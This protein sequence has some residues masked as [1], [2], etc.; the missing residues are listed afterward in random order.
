MKRAILRGPSQLEFEDIHLNADGLSDDQIYAETEFSA[1]SVGTESAAYLGQPPLRPG[2]P[3]PRFVGYCNAGK[4]TRLGRE[5]RGFKVGDRILT[6]QSHQSAFV[7]RSE[8]VLAWVPEFVSTKVASL[9]YLAHLGLAAL[10][11]ANF[12]PGENIAVLGLGLIGLATVNVAATLGARVVALGNDDFRQK[13]A[14]ELGAHACFRS[15]DPNLKQQI[16]AATAGVGI[17]LL[18][19]TANSWESWRIALETPRRQGRIAVLGFPGRSEGLPRFNPFDPFCF[20]SKQLSIFAAGSVPECHVAPSEIRF[21][22]Q[23]NMQM[24][25]RL[26]EERKLSLDQ[27]ITHC[28]PW[29]ELRQIYELAGRKDKTMIAAV[30]DWGK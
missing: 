7:C 24:L 9:T 21:T 4:V 3:Y 11:K 13:K 1:V 26:M 30:L 18:I 22:L 28:V 25:L 14:A 12:R 29:H 27:L 17:D 6:H 8:G 20:Y 5:V 15:D 2:S 16:E 23:R 19:T 10:Q